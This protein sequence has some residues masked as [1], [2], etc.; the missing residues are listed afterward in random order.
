LSA[1]KPTGPAR[2]YVF[3]DIPTFAAS[4]DLLLKFG[5][6][7]CILGDVKYKQFNGDPESHDLYQLLVHA[8]T[9]DAT[10]AFLL[11]PGA[12]YSVRRLGTSAS[13]IQVWL[14]TLDIRSIAA[15]LAEFM[16]EIGMGSPA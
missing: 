8:D 5:T 13:G 3:P 2:K 11:Y 6:E 1:I 15:G 14:A 12:S 9:Y 16:V 7:V 10:G 4:P